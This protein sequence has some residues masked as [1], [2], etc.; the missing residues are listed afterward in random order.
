MTIRLDRCEKKLGPLGVEDA[1][2]ELSGK[3]RHC[4]VYYRD[5]S[6]E[7]PLTPQECMDRIKERFK[8]ILL[9]YSFHGKEVTVV[10][11]LE[12][13]VYECGAYESQ[14]LVY[15]EPEIKN[16]E[17]VITLEKLAEGA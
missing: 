14:T 4:F 1:L 6:S 3:I 12:R 17:S 16:R 15:E 5:L 2:G 9:V 13:A 8:D 11:P 10:S 7:G